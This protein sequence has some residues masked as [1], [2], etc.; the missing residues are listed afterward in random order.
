MRTYKGRDGEVFEA[1]VSTHPEERYRYRFE[2]RRELR[3]AR[4][5]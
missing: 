1:T 3:A 4:R 5:R 2:F